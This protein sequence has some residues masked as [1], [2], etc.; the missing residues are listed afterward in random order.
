M[1][2]GKYLSLDEAEG[3]IR[4]KTKICSNGNSNRQ[5]QQTVY[6]TTVRYGNRWL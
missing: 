1:V 2:V 4:I 6:R 3:K 5:D